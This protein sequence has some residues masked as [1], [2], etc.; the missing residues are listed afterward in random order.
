MVKE[1]GNAPIAGHGGPYGCETSRLS[2]FLDNRF[3]DGGEVSLTRLP[4]I[5]SRKISDTDFC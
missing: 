5:I 3:T 4:L 1:K 2:V